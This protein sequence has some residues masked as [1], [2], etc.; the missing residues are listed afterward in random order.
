[1]APTVFAPKTRPTRGAG[2]SG[3]PTPGNRG[4]EHG[5]GRAEPD[6]GRNEESRR[7]GEAHGLARRERPLGPQP[8][9]ERDDVGEAVPGVQGQGN[10]HRGG[11][12]AEG[13]D[14]R[15]G[16][17]FADEPRHGEAAETDADEDGG[18]HQ[19][20]RVDRH[21]DDRSDEVRPGDLQR[22]REGSLGERERA[23]EPGRQSGVAGARAGGRHGKLDP[24]LAV[25]GC[26]RRGAGAPPLD[27][28]AAT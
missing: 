19:R 27:D 26:A 14:G 9:G 11:E 28:G 4:G 22:E 6:R 7:E 2:R 21:A 1:M 24:D 17:A 12:L 10:P 8:E 23:H 16:D 15:R 3:A 13:G 18:E 25:S 20:E 5:Q